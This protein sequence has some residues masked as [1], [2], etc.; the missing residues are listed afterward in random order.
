VGAGFEEAVTG[1]LLDRLPP[2]YR[3]SPVR[4]HPLILALAARHHAEATLGGTRE[5]YRGLR[6]E[7]RDRLEPDDIGTGLTAME[8]LAAQFSRMQREV[9]LVEQALRGA[10]WKPRL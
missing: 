3:L 4:R 2:E 9:V 8:A 10:V 7:L 6:A 1:W 5:V